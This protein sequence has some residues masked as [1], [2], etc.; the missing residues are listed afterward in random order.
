VRRPIVVAGVLIV[1]AAIA[2]IRSSATASLDRR[3]GIV[4][5]VVDGDTLDVKF[6]DGTTVRVALLGVDAPDVNGL[7]QQAMA[8]LAARTAKQRV[9]LRLDELPRSGDRIAAYVYLADNELL[10]EAIVRD[11]LAFADRERPCDFS[12]L[13]EQ[14]ENAA[15]AAKRGMWRTI[16]VDQMPAWRQRW[17]RE[18]GLK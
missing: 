9:T 13:I 16:T 2:L 4:T 11:G 8:Y 12:G 17:M 3:S 18:R 1:V 5:S 14:T 6:D 10:N 7:N 15:R